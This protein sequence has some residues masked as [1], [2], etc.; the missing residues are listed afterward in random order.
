MVRSFG[1]VMNEER[2]I[3]V[4]LDEIASYFGKSRKTIWRWIQHQGFPAA[5]LPTGEWF[6]TPTLIDDWILAR[7]AAYPMARPKGKREV[8]E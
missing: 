7:N 2:Q 5:P 8:T 6:T 4:G 3:L 1:M